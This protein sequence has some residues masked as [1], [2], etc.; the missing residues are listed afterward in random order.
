MTTSPYGGED[1]PTRLE[2]LAQEAPHMNHHDV[3]RLTRKYTAHNM[4]HLYGPP[5][6]ADPADCYCGD[7]FEDH[8]VGASACRWCDCNGYAER[9]EVEATRDALDTDDQLD[10]ERRRDNTQA[11]IELEQRRARRTA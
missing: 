2:A 8:T 5:V 10:G 7:A 3:A 6:Y 9:A 11:A 4:G 1:T